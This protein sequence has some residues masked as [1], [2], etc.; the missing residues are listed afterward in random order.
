MAGTGVAVGDGVAVGAGVHVAVGDGDSGVA[1]RLTDMLQARSKRE[2]AR[3]G[4]SLFIAAS[5][6]GSWSSKD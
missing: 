5:I 1:P 6:G 3:S 4:T 2:M